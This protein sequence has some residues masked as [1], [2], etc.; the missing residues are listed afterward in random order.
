MGLTLA[1]YVDISLRNGLV[2]SQRSIDLN[3]HDLGAAPSR[4]SPGGL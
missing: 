3:V 2:T 4:V 1:H